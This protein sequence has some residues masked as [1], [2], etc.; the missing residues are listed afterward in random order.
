MKYNYK[1]LTFLALTAVMLVLPAVV[2]PA[3]TQT[4]TTTSNATINVYVAIS[5]SANLSDG[6]LFGNVE[7][8]TNDNNA[9]HNNDSNGG[10]TS[11]WILV[12]QDSNVNVDLCLN[13][14]ESLTSGSYTIP[15]ANYT[16]NNSQT[17]QSPDLSGTAMT[18]TST[19]VESSIPTTSDA[20]AYFRFWLDVP[21]GQQAGTYVNEMSFKAIQ[22]GGTC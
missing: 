17:D 7:V 8:N 11:M 19:K 15:D 1:F 6:I 13:Y 16:Y 2:T 4:V 10:N 22:A 20:Y 9:S 3:S 14:N 12:S 18:T 21:V 5:R